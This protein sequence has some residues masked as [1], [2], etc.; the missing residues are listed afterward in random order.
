MFNTA[1]FLLLWLYFAVSTLIAYCFLMTTAA[2]KLQSYVAPPVAKLTGF[3][4]AALGAATI[5]QSFSLKLSDMKIVDVQHLIE[6]YGTRV[7][8]DILKKSA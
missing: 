2:S 7:V 6:N 3:V 1:S 5:L 8:A 4:L